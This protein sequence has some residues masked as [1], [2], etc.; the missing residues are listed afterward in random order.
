MQ[1]TLASARECGGSELFIIIFEWRGE[2]R[3]QQSEHKTK[4]KQRRLDKVFQRCGVD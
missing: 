3:R 4:S 2:A 1:M